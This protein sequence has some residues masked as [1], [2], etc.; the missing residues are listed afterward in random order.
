MRPFPERHYRTPV[1][2]AAREVTDEDGDPV[3]HWPGVDGWP[4]DVTEL[5]CN[6]GQATP[7]SRWTHSVE[8]SLTKWELWFS[9]PALVEAGV[10]IRRGDRL[11][12]T[13]AYGPETVL[14][15]TADAVDFNLLGVSIF[16]PCEEVD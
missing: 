7:Q 15:P 3:D 2:H 8:E 12:L 4:G 1:V 10:T 11:T 14:R 6:A 13:P 16:V 9:L 5:M